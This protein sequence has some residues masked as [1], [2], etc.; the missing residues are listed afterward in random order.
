MIDG[1]PQ[2][3]QALQVSNLAKVRWLQRPQP[4]FAGATPLELLRQGRID[5]VLAEAAQVGRGQD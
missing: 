4:V 1:L 2:V 3:L 5:E